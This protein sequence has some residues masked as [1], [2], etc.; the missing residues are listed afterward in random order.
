[1]D[2]S[3]K[4]GQEWLV[5]DNGKYF[6]FSTVEIFVGASPH[7]WRRWAYVCS[8]VKLSGAEPG[9]VEPLL[10]R[11]DKGAVEVQF[12]TSGERII[13]CVELRGERHET[14]R[15]RARARQPKPAGR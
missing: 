11:S 9:I 8:Y 14:T 15:W 1:M 5:I 3:G 4:V 7:R 6:E 2:S 12:D 13:G 10:R